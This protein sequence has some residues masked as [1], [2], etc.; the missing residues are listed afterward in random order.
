MRTFHDYEFEALIGEGAMGRVWRARQLAFDGRLVALKRVSYGDPQLAERLRR[1]GRILAQ[2]DHPHIIRVYELIPDGQGI[3]IAMQYAPGGSLADLLERQGRLT[4]QATVQ[5]LAPIAQALGSAHRRGI[6][7]RDVKPSN[8]LFTSDGEPLL[9]DFGIAR[10]SGDTPLTA[11]GVS[12]LGTAEYLDPEIVNGGEPNARSDV[13]ALGAVSYETLSGRRPF[14]AP[15]PIA[16]LRLADRGKAASLTSIAPDVGRPLAQVVAQ[17]MARKP[18]RRF[19]DAGDLAAAL[20]DSLRPTRRSAPSAPPP[21]TSP[22][23]PT[24]PASTAPAPAPPAPP[25]EE[26]VE[27]E[28]VAQQAR[29]STP[30]TRAF[31]PRPLAPDSAPRPRRRWGTTRWV[32]VA[33]IV[34]L[35]LTATLA[36][37]LVL[38]RQDRQRLTAEVERL[39]I[40]RDQVREQLRDAS[41]P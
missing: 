3:A 16:V 2:L 23:A 40:E 26:H 7:H 5:V 15:T 37:L 25:A 11:P 8:I 22:P 4:P 34:V 18:E 19:A 36:T 20:Q 30:Q 14:E 35:L 38:E 17:A 24:A 21:P 41:Q 1:E 31:G 28:W 32:A 27:A 12:A 13:Y 29:P 33:L 10:V 9:S 6:V 39:Q